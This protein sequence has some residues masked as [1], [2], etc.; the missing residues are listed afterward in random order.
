MDIKVSINISSDKVTIETSNNNY[1]LL[2][3][4]VDNY[5]SL[6]YDYLE[7]NDLLDRDNI[8]LILKE[9]F[10]YKG[11]LGLDINHGRL[12]KEIRKFEDKIT[13]YGNIDEIKEK[14]KLSSNEGV[15]NFIKYIKLQKD[16]NSL[17]VYDCID[18]IGLCSHVIDIWRK[19]KYYNRWKYCINIINIFINDT[20]LDKIKKLLQNIL[21]YEEMN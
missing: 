6:S 10:M 16:I 21:I 20:M 1:T 13:Q 19:D 9:Y 15:S 14:L 11:L 18:I 3:K 5:Y 7:Y 17:T 4:T 2:S 8:S 12:F